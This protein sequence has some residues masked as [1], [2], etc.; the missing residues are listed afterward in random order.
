MADVRADQEE[1]F[2]RGDAHEPRASTRKR[3]TGRR[4]TFR[5][6]SGLV[7]PKSPPHSR[8]PE[9]RWVERGTDIERAVFFSD[10]VFAIAITLLALEIRVPDDP[11][12]LS[13]S[14]LAL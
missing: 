12:D 11:T 13:Q 5:G 8:D 14:L 1:G 10:A 9:E 3:L 2:A 7:N 6:G 4:T